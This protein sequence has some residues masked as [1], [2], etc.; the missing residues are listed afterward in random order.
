MIVYMDSSLRAAGV[1]TEQPYKNL[2]ATLPTTPEENIRYAIASSYEGASSLASSTKPNI[3]S[4]NQ[5]LKPRD[6]T[7]YGFFHSSTND[8]PILKISDSDQIKDHLRRNLLN[9]VF[10]NQTTSNPQDILNEKFIGKLLEVVCD[11]APAVKRIGRSHNLTSIQI[12]G[13]QPEMAFSPSLTTSIETKL[14]P[15]LRSADGKRFAELH[16]D[17]PLSI[18][19]GDELAEAIC[20]FTLGCIRIN[21][22]PEN[23]LII[24]QIQLLRHFT[25]QGDGK[26]KYRRNPSFIKNN[27]CP[28]ILVEN[29]M[30]IAGELGINQV[31]IIP[32][33]QHLYYHM[34]PNQE[35]AEF[36]YEGTAQRLGFHYS[37][38]DRIYIKQI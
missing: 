37:E 20:S 11:F 4:I 30:R 27:D 24:S 17:A 12:S 5:L 28:K 15:P 21:G 29:V 33:A 23:I 26:V 9:L 16:A 6:I 7:D 19:I 35:K 3:L 8:L 10:A 2:L 18:M 38:K 22:K 25:L 36:M 34:I 31:G 32:V 13:I 14:A 1:V